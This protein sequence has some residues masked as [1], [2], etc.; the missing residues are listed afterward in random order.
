MNFA[1]ATLDS[2]ERDDGWSSSEFE[3]CDEAEKDAV[4]T[5]SQPARP[6]DNQVRGQRGS[7]GS[8]RDGAQRDTKLIYLPKK[9]VFY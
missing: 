2:M 1:T 5:S 8:R 3:S 7:M 9:N 6:V 4:S